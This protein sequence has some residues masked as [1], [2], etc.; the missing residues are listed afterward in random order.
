[1]WGNQFACPLSLNC[2]HQGVPRVL[3][4]HQITQDIFL[5]PSVLVVSPTVPTNACSSVL[6]TVQ[7][8]A[9][10]RFSLC[11]DMTRV[12]LIERGIGFC[13]FLSRGILWFTSTYTTWLGI[14]ILP[15]AH[16]TIIRAGNTHQQTPV[17]HYA[18][19]NAAQQYGHLCFVSQ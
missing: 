8:N 14:G 7:H 9:C 10:Q 4:K 15:S 12:G 2:C 11:H 17:R 6:L 1:M 13:C 5:N 16:S 19:S 3:N 18:T